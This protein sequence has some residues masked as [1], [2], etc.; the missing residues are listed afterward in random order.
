MT[1]RGTAHDY[2]PEEVEPLYTLDFCDDMPEEQPE[3]AHW[4]NSALV[5]LQESTGVTL[6]DL[7]VTPEQDT[8]PNYSE[9]ADRLNAAGFDTYDS[10]T[11]FEVFAGGAK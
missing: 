1:T 11:L 7:Q 8:D 3:R 5:G 10:D 6:A 2:Q 4:H 9:V